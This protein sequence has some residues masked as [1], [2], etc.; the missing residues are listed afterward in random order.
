MRLGDLL[1]IIVPI[2]IAI[3]VYTLAF[4]GSK[5]A[6]VVAAKGER[7]VALSKQSIVTITANHILL[8]DNLEMDGP[9]RASLEL[10]TKRAC[11]FVF[12][13]VKDLEEQERIQER[14]AKQFEG[15]IDPDSILYCQTAM[16]RASM[17]R[18]L[19]AVSHIDF[20]P[21]VVHQVAIFHKTVLIAPKT[22]D[23]P[24]AAWRCGSFSEF[25][26]NGNTEFLELLHR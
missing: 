1:V 24:H 12:V 3:L 25:M 17:S 26:T 22:V 6:N 4:S 8:D 14:I 5:P 9:T 23:S 18:Q 11:V 19:D 7:D 2:L 16:G 20:D 21:E 15:L 10:L 13:V